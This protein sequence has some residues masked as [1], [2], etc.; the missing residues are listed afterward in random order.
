MDG[1]FGPLSSD[2]V[3]CRHLQLSLTGYHVVISVFFTPFSLIL[4]AC[5][6]AAE[7]VTVS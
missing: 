3:S 4:L 2:C 6:R 7:V 5:G 1:C